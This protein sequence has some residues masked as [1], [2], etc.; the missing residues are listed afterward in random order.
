MEQLYPTNEKRRWKF[1]NKIPILSY[2]KDVKPEPRKFNQRA[3]SSRIPTFARFELEIDFA[4][5][6]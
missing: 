6:E 4:I 3:I 5:I 2:L 1:S